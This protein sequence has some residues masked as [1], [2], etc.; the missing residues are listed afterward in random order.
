MIGKTIGNLKIVSEL[1]KGGMGVVYL[2]EHMKLDKKFAVK[3]LSPEFTR[4]PLFRER[5][6]QEAKNQAL[7]DHPNIVQATDFF[8][9]NGQYLLVM[10]YVEGKE[11]SDLIKGKGKL[12]EDEALLIIKDVLSGLGFA[13]RKGMIHRDMKPSNIMVG[14]DGRT[15]IMDFGIAILA[16]EKRLTSTGTGTIGTSWYMSPEQIRHP[17]DIDHRSDIYSLG[18][19]MFEML[20]GDVPFDG[21]TEFNI[22]E[23]QVNKPAPDPCGKNP[24]ISKELS[25]MILKAM[26][27]NPDDRFQGC[28]EFLKVIKAYKQD[29][30]PPP[31]QPVNWLVR[32]LLVAVVLIVGLLVV[33]LA[34]KMDSKTVIVSVPPGQNTEAEYETVNALIQTGI[35]QASLVCR[36]SAQ[37]PFKKEN[38]QSAQE[39]GNPELVNS[40]K[41]NIEQINQNIVNGVSRYNQ[42]LTQLAASRKT[43]VAEEFD[44]Q[45]QKAMARLVREHYQLRSDNGKDLDLDTLRDICRARSQIEK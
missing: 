38:L 21:E 4:D 11:L 12:T 32:A 40:Y 34:L 13:H 8:E 36:E 18:I 22:Q 26:E 3:S 28:D 35:E 37:L 16:G 14:N 1:G 45:S 19:I 33:H 10:E 27:K 9:E 42:V 39:V 31:P 44:K 41:K 29:I 5:F 43:V 7:L 15:R 6:Y 25:R 2:A 17:K 20:T 30:L 24:K 23:Q